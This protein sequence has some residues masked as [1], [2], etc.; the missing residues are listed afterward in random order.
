M[1]S[2]TS[3]STHTLFYAYS[4]C[5]CT[6]H[7][8]IPKSIRANYFG[9]STLIGVYLYTYM[10]ICCFIFTTAAIYYSNDLLQQ[11]FTTAAIY[12]SSRVSDQ[13]EQPINIP[14]ARNAT[15][16]PARYTYPDKA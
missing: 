1:Y 9:T 15:Y 5:N 10:H 6:V 8:N 11:R 12:Y 16:T 7:A 14:T 13:D 4:I 2:I 3:G